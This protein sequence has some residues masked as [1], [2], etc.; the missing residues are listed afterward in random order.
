M[1]H[2][3]EILERNVE[4]LSA[5]CEKVTERIAVAENSLKAV[6]D[7]LDSMSGQTEII[8]KISTVVDHIGKQL[9]SA[10]FKME[11]YDKKIE[12]LEKQPGQVALKY[13]HLIASSLVGGAVGF[14]LRVLSNGGI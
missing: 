1:E 3:V 11:E 13:W 9:D 8:I 6:H 7:R 12:E 10:L 5:K 2:R 14:F 4:R